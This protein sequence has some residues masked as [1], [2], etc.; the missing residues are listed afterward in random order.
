MSVSNIPVSYR[1][2]TIVA[3]VTMGLIITT[4]L[5][6][7]TQSSL[8]FSLKYKELE[9]LSDN[10]VSILKKYHALAQ[11]GKMSEE[12][13]RAKALEAVKDMRYG[14]DGY[15]WINDMHP[16]MVMHPIKPKLNGKDLSNF[17]DPNGV[18]LFNEAVKVVK[19]KGR[20]GIE[21]SW[22]KPGFEN[23]VPKASYVI[24]FSPWNMMVGTGVYIDDLENSLFNSLINSLLIG[25]FILL[26][27]SAVTL[28]M[29][30]S[31]TK[32]LKILKEAMLKL[33]AGETGFELL[34][35]DRKDEL[36]EMSS[37]VEIFRQNALERSRLESQQIADREKEGQRQQNIEVL[38]AEFRDNV[39]QVLQAVNENVQK[40]HNNTNVLSDIAE[41]TADRSKSANT[42]STDASH[43]VQQV[44]SA[45]E[46]LSASIGE[47]NHQ[48]SQTSKVVSEAADQ[49]QSTNHKVEGLAD[50]AQKIGDV[51]NLIQDIAEQTNLLALNATIEAARAG[52]MGKGFAVVASEVKSLAN[53]TAKATE[54][55]SSQISAIQESTGGAVEAI[56]GI[57]KIMEEANV[58][59]S[60]IASAVE[61]Q[62]AA[63]NEIGRNVQHAAKG[64]M[65]AVENMTNVSS[66]VSDTTQSV[67][68][69]RNSSKD[70]DTQ[71][72]ELKSVIDN[73]LQK[74]TA[75]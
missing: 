47:I 34:P 49:A 40:M 32:P 12:D 52:D 31:V 39:S 29:A 48:V 14:K 18:F 41:K 75:A 8:A 1:I 65:D 38:I 26:S 46:E 61:E 17:K 23:P 2:F 44:A 20:G 13:A 7:Y 43:S 19:D 68:N 58:Y 51:V 22:P 30:N 63:T 3:F 70:V 25:L 56:Q 54:E 10:A 53:Q 64:T 74:V 28:I 73:F 37:A 21:Y 27:I 16:K 55:I 59:A 67:V 60:A 45:A 50:M 42:A 72:N 36:G 6:I 71:T 57:A 11:S 15:F 66:S 9:N 69:V 4:M 35:S 24:G 62:G 33:G 5:N